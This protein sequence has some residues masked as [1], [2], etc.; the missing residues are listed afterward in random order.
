MSGPSAVSENAAR[1]QL[2]AERNLHLVSD[3]EEG[4]PIQKVS[5][6]VYGFTY[7]PSTEAVPLYAKRTFQ[8]FEAHKLADGETHLVGF[9]KPSEAAILRAGVDFIEC[10]LYP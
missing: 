10:N 1:E 2:R 8:V 3:D 7:S 9:V 4:W 5:P 6:G